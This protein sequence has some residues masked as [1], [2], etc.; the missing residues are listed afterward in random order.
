M[1]RNYT[2]Y[3]NTLIPVITGSKGGKGGGGGGA[4]ED[5]NSLFSTDIVFITSGLGEGPVYRINSNGPQDIEIQDN[6]IDDLID[7]SDNTTDDEKFVTLSTTGTTTQDRLDVFG[8]SIVTPQN[9]ASPVSLK[10]GNL[11]GVPSVSVTDQETSAQAWD[12]LKFNFALNGL[13]KIES[14]GDIKIHTVSIKITIKKR[15]LVGNPLIDNITEVSKTITGKTN[16]TFKFSVKVNIPAAYRDDAGYRF[17]IEKTSDDSASSGTTDNIQATGWFEIEN[18]PQSYPRTAVVGYALKAVD[19]HQNGI[20]NFTSLVKGLIVKVPSNYNQPILENGEIDWRNVEI[21]SSL[22]GG[23]YYLQSSGT[24]SVQTNPNPQIYVGSWDGTF[25]YSWTQN[26]VWI[27]YDI[28]TNNT[29]GLGVPEEYIDKYKF[30]QVAQ[31]CD[32]CDSVTGK[33]YGVD[34]LADGSFRHKPRQQYTT[35]RENQL[36]LPSGTAIKQRRFTMDVTIADEGPAMDIINEL[37]AS[38]RATI[39]YSLGKLTLAV[40]MPDEFPVA[41]FNETNIKQG[42]VVI[43]GTKESDIISGVDVSYIDPTNHYKRETVRVDSSDSNDGVEKNII[44]NISSLDL[45]GVTRRSQALRFAQYHIASSKYQRRSISFTT[46]TDALQLAP[47]DVISVAQQSSGVAYG[48]SGKISANSAIGDASNTNVF[49]EHFTSPS[50]SSSLFTANTGPLAFRVIKRKTDKV[51]LYI[52]SN[53]AF[54]LTTTDNVSTGV[55]LAEINAIQKYNKQSKTFDNISSW[56]TDDGPEEGDLWSLGEIAN[57]GDFYT[58]KAGK[59]FKITAID[60]EPKE[61]EVTITAMEYISNVYVD[62]DTFID[63]TPTA[64]TDIISPLSV[65]PAPIFTFDAQPRRRLDGS[66]AVDGFLNFRNEL[67]G[68]NQDLRTEYFLSRP[69]AATLVN[70]TYTSSGSLTFAVSN[71]DAISN[72]QTPSSLTGKNGFET[73]IGE[74][75]LLANAITT[76]DTGGGTLDGNVE[77]TLEGL[78]VAFD[79]NF[80]KHVLEVNDPGVFNNLK[81]SDFVS[82]PI[83]EKTSPQGLLNF[84][85]YASDITELSVNIVGYDKSTNTLKFENTKTNGLNLV[86]LLPAAPFYVSINQLLD[87]RYFSNNSFYVKGSEFTYVTEGNLGTTTTHIPLEVS[88]RASSFARLY[89]DGVLK[90]SGQY[91]VNLNKGLS[92]DANIVYTSTPGDLKYRAEIDHYTVPAIEV[93]DNVQTSFN[94]TFAVVNTS[95]DPASATYNAALTANS[96]FRVELDTT[97]TSNLTGFSFVNITTDPVGTVAN[98]SGNTCTLDYNESTYPGTFNLGNNRIYSLNIGSEFEKIFVAQ[99]QI[100]RDL[101]IGT[102]TVKARNKNVLGRFS[103]F[104]TKSVTVSAIPIQRVTGLSVTESLYREQ[105]GG[106]AVRATCIFN[107][108]TGQE[109]TDYEISYRLATVDDIGTNDGGA[110]L[111]SFNT[112]KVPATGVDDDGKIRFT[113]NGLNRGATSELNSITFRVTPLNKDIR[114]K[115]ASVTKTIVGKTAAPSNIFNFTGGQNTDQITLLWQYPRAASGDLLDLDLKEVVVKRAPGV[116][117]NTVANFVASDALV[118]VSAGTARKSIPID[119]FGEFTYLAR[120][121]DTS[122]NFSEDVQSI[123]LTTTRPDRST[124]V[125]GI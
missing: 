45:R 99:D 29:Y 52:L 10:K 17:T 5:P 3:H 97:P 26:P 105:T 90:S 100:I 43:T 83:K 56:N 44:R 50:L 117:A 93:G 8:E 25:V 96:I 106:V 34:A 1:A 32:A 91:T 85:G 75:K 12:A 102:T 33:F 73:T 51:D 79:E 74:I 16:T 41:V 65:P 18:A 113:V 125:A 76:V 71:A 109:V 92:I 80:F 46:S 42:S 88:P 55:D 108:I 121:R 124:V 21:T 19:E 120:T 6:T 68:Y 78:N 22:I 62:S 95:F 122:G 47:G 57:A 61:E 69:D 49:I 84:V 70:N 4:S 116:V 9:F 81:G 115:T 86:D 53:T 82:I 114:G 103:P 39:V 72:G 98:V 24:G 119:T 30:Y 118:T 13:Q 2:K 40:D 87:A 89:I 38:F 104:T 123:T 107:H 36:G 77:L 23:G 111:T 15:V 11:E 94:N 101:P 60:R 35:V 54:E 27:I 31:Y 58:N 7:F 67:I 64:Y 20:P 66:V 110:D 48:Y 14:N 112:V 37:C 63:Y 59:L 28:L